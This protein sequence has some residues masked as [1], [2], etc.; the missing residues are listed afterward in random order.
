VLD[1]TEDMLGRVV[2]A[3]L[4][5]HRSERIFEVLSGGNE[6]LC[7]DFDVFTTEDLSAFLIEQP[8]AGG[9]QMKLL[10]CVL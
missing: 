1:R 2:F 6:I 9:C 10:G 4:T 7:I 8:S 3:D 5:F